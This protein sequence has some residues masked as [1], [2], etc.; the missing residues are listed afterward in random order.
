MIAHHL[1]VII[2]LVPLFGA[3]LSALTK[4]GAVAWGIALIATVLTLAAT[5]GLLGHVLHDG[6]ISYEIGG[7][8]PPIGIEYRVD[9]ANALVILI[10]ATIATV[11]MPYA[12]VSVAKELA[13]DQQ[14]WFYTMY[15]LCV[16]GLIGI[17]VTGD[18]FN[19]FV[20]LEVSSLATYTMIALGQSRRSLLSAY[21]YLIMGTIGAT[22]YIIGIGLLLT[23]TGTLNFVDLAARIAVTPYDRA[24]LTALAFI[25]VG[26]GLKLAL[27]PLHVWLPNA[28]A[29]APS[30]GTALLASTAT[31]VAVYLLIR[32]YFNVFGIS[33]IVGD[34][35][36]LELLLVLSI[37]AM[38]FA[39]F[40]AVFEKNV[41]RL[42]AYSSV[43]QVGYM[44][45]GLS[46]ATSTALTGTLVHLANHAMMKGAAFLA[47]GAVSYQLGSV[48]LERMKGIGR[49]MPVT[50][51][52][53]VVAGLSLIGVPGTVGFI[54]KYYL[55]VAAFEKGWWW[56]AFM[57]VASSLIAVFYVGRV[58]EVAW[59]AEPSKEAAKLKEAPLSLLLPT[60][61]LAAACVF[62][63]VDASLT[64]G[65][66][67]AAANALFG[68]SL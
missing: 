41:K 17:A 2:V 25:T 68:G 56:L 34:V 46:M 47:I 37:A 20:F 55:V 9:M 57:I 29:R 5:I 48:S 49:V 7:W 32:V 31:K 67:E 50:M 22:F 35:P 59:F 14:A 11:I 15:M 26:I 38:F 21:Q 44:I 65:L 12:R 64:A 10:V 30:T 33:N 39:S 61:A 8:A 42:L 16:A 1:P 23:I 4:R 19:A 6:V 13:A 43:A 52:C 40:V 45:L 66:A 36:V 51:G 53:F 3:L 24:M 58:V 60:V 27:F 62:F 63:G 18:A 28:Y 54:S